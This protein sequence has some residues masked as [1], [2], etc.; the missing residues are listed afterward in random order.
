MSQ[1]RAGLSTR[2]AGAF[3]TELWG[4]SD[5]GLVSGVN[6]FTLV[7]L[8]R[9]LEPVEFGYFVLAFTILQTAT[10]TP[11]RNFRGRVCSEHSARFV[12]RS[13]SHTRVAWCIAT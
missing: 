10:K 7:L 2:L 5:Q 6:F 4:L 11:S 13:I 9:G 3:H 1:A 8:A 12:W